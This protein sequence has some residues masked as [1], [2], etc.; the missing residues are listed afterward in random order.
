MNSNVLSIYRY[1]FFL[2][3][4]ER[5]AFQFYFCR[6]IHITES[7]KMSLRLAVL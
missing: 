5:I 4:E 2:N 1:S 7:L 6:L 3:A